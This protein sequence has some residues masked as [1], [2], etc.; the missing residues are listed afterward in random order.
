MFKQVGDRIRAIRESKNL[1]QANMAEEL[2]MKHSSGYSKIEGGGN[3]TLKRI[4]EIA[5]VLN[6]D[7]AV[8][9]QD[10]KVEVGD[11]NSRY[12]YA[13]KEEVQELTKTVQS[14]LSLVE[15]LDQKVDGISKISGKKNSKVKK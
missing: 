14:L 15:K 1:T 5:E 10:K 3:T 7:V 9:F 12:G 4:F 13:T 11:S 8:F 6:V 2:D